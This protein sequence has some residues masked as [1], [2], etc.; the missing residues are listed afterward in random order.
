M[1]TEIEARE[2]VLTAIAPGPKI[3]MP[4]LN[5]LGRYAAVELR[6]TVPL[7][8]FDNS[9]MDG[10]AV[11]AV[12]TT[13]PS[14]PISVVGEQ[15]AGRDLG[16]ECGQGQAIR[17]FTGAPMPAG[18]DAVIMQE[19]VERKG[20]AIFCRESVAQGENI[21]HAGADLCEGQILLRRG[22][23]LTPGRL[24]VL[25][26]Q[27]LN[28]VWVHATP[29]V[30]VLSTGDELVSAGQPLAAGQIYNSNGLMLQGML[31][32]QGIHDTLAVHCPDDLEA[33]MSTVRQLLQS[34]D[35][36][37]LSGGV[38]VG[39]HDH[40]KPALLALGITPDLWRVKVKPGKPFLFAQHAGKFIFGL[41]G[42]PVSSYMTYQLFVRPAML[43]WMGAAEVAPVQ[44]SAISA[45]DLHNDGNRPHYLRG[46]LKEGV[47]TVQ[48]LQQSHALFALSQAN[49]LL[50]LESDERVTAGQMVTV[51]I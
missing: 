27:G 25:A 30:A 10:Y 14:S 13:D 41:P 37:L 19:D 15:P 50:R 46:V 8:G 5:A 39:D 26:S 28:N 36:I 35:V 24:G 4:L 33:T 47:F 31:A 11:R 32:V 23:C 38:S 51:L 18:A 17:I 42:N 16:L 29:R 22:E 6:A 9:M 44:I 45:G 48:G 34:H 2:R 49:A 1:I 7:P 12:E 40:I 21:R 20:E 43:R 3:E